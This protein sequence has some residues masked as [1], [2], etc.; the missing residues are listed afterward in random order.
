MQVDWQGRQSS[1]TELSSCRGRSRRRRAT[2]TPAQL[3]AARK[4]GECLRRVLSWYRRAS[5]LLPRMWTSRLPVAVWVPETPHASRDLLI[6]VEQSTR[7][8][9]RWTM[10]VSLVVG[11]GSGR[12][13]AAWPRVRCGRCLF[14][15]AGQWRESAPRSSSRVA[16]NKSRQITTCRRFATSPAAVGMGGLSSRCPTQQFPVTLPY[17][18][19]KRS[20]PSRR[21]AGQP[22]AP[23]ARQP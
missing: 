10:L 8:S 17:P 18:P 15:G 22:M 23:L 16:V 5:R 7:R 4:G 9:C 14:S 3:T 21:R 13:G 1:G 6:L 20:R 12:R 2:T 19:S 11:W